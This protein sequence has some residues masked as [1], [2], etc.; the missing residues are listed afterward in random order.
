MQITFVCSILQPFFDFFLAA[1]SLSLLS[2]SLS[3]TFLS[4]FWCITCL[5]SRLP[6]NHAVYLCVCVCVRVRSA[7]VCLCDFNASTF[8]WRFVL[9]FR[10]SRIRSMCPATF[11]LAF[12]IWFFFRFS[13]ISFYCFSRFVVLPAL[14][15]FRFCQC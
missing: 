3:L 6:G 8:Y 13:F 14:L 9:R 1:S 4:I 15:P 2:L 7:F 12:P 10:S 5:I 11:L